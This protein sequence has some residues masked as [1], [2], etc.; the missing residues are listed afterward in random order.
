VSARPIDQLDVLAE[1]HGL[2]LHLERVVKRWRLGVVRPR[3]AVAA[4]ARPVRSYEGMPDLTDASVQGASERLLAHLA[5]APPG[6][7]T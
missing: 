6:R 4:G 5:K 7:G 3:R 1:H 2:H